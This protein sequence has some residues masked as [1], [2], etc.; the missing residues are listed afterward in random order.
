MLF[1]SYLHGHSVG[2]T[3]PSLLEALGSTKLNLLLGVGFNR[4]VGEKAALYWTCKQGSL[5][6]LIDK[7]DQL[8]DAQIDAY[9]RLTKK[10]IE[11]SYQWESITEQYQDLF[12]K[13]SASVRKV[14]NEFLYNYPS[15]QEQDLF[16]GVFGIG[17]SEPRRR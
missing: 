1:R 13:E 9:G 3:N 16:G 14:E 10:R 8:S 4:E 11:D 12:H 7:A 17:I 5:S 15:K 2:G 6:G